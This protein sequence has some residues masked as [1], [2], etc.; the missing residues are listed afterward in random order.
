MDAVPQSAPPTTREA[1]RAAD[2]LR[3]E[4]PLEL[5]T[6]RDPTLRLPRKYSF[7]DFLN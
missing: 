3:V 7:G 2:P 6:P 1:C 4:H 5:V